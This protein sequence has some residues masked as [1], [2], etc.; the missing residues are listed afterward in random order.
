MRR[1]KR[2]EEGEGRNLAGSV[3]VW[4]W[5]DD[6]SRRGIGDC[7]G[8]ASRVSPWTHLTDGCPVGL[9]LRTRVEDGRVGFGT[10]C[11]CVFVSLL[12]VSERCF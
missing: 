1:E 5:W 11:W 9:F 6:G 7:S 3:S 4:D 12:E 10:W 2:G 8:L